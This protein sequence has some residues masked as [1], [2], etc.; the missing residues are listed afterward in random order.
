MFFAGDIPYDRNCG[1]FVLAD[2][3][4]NDG[5][6]SKELVLQLIGQLNLQTV[7]RYCTCSSCT[8]MFV[9]I[10]PGKIREIHGSDTEIHIVYE[11]QPTNDFK[12]LFKN[13]NG[14]NLETLLM[15]YK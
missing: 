1:P 13:L 15:S 4:T 3:G 11:D 7:C 8:G 5:R 2:Y 6:T 9:N 14:W 12:S 10:K